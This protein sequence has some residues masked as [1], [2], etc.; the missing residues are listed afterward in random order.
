MKLLE[1][2]PI[3][4][5]L[6][7]MPTVTLAES[8]LRFRGRVEPS[9]TVIVANH[10]KGVVQEL[11]FSGGEHVTAGDLLALIDPRDFEIAVRAARAALAEA[12]AALRLA[13]DDAR[14]QAELLARATGS[15]VAALRAEVARD[16]AVAERDRRLAELDAANL[17]LRRARV[18]API[19]GTISLPLV[20]EGAFVEAKA[21]TALAEI[22]TLDPVRVAYEVSYAERSQALAMAEVATPTELFE[23]IELTLTLPSG[24]DYP[25]VGR[26]LAESAAI[27][28]ETGTITVWGLFPNPGRTLVPFLEVS[29]TASL[30]VESDR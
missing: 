16:A 13:D 20:T 26:P 15:R 10:V 28:P 30:R 21:G 4:L 25:H 29:V 19:S 18:H 12:E 2:L 27:D 9:R 24:R 6:L 5:A 17:A 11:R 7:V 14:R 8:T 23:R 3:A 22:V 1:T